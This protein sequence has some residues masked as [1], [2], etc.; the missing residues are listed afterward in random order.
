MKSPLIRPESSAQGMT[1]KPNPLVKPILALLTTDRSF[2]LPENLLLLD[3]G[4]G[5]LRHLQLMRAFAKRIWIVDTELQVTQSQWFGEFKGS[6]QEFVRTLKVRRNEV[7][8]LTTEELDSRDSI[9]DVVI[10]VA[11]MDVV[12]VKTRGSVVRQ[13]HKAL[14]EDGYFVVIVPRNDTSILRRCTEENV[15]EDGHIFKRGKEAYT[16]FSNF[17]D[18]GALVEMISR[19][20]FVIVEDRSNHKQVCLIFKKKRG[21]RRP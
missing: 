11:V 5:K 3:L 19:A 21:D 17:R 10:S 20:G 7:E 14:R 1:A 6:M 9:A 8:A 16:F 13:A 15:F 2:G 12:P 4:C 18:H